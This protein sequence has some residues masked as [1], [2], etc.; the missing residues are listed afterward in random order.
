MCIY[1]YICI[2]VIYIYT[3]MYMF[4]VIFPLAASQLR[5]SSDPFYLV[6]QMPALGMGESDR[7]SK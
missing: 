2:H 1:I 5:L 4:M 6:L 7:G 3:Y